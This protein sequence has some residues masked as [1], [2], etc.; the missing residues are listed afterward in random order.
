MPLIPALTPPQTMQLSS[1]SGLA[2]LRM[3]DRAHGPREAVLFFRRLFH[4]AR[5]RGHSTLTDE[6]ENRFIEGWAAGCS[7]IWDTNHQSWP[8][9]YAAVGHV[10]A[11]EIKRLKEVSTAVI[12]TSKVISY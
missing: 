12:D 4:E 9:L 5:Q 11:A 10:I 1:A 3:P 8:L 6:Q 7:E 2:G